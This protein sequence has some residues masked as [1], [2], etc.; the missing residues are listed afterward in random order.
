MK[1][2]V[3]D[4]TFDA[5]NKTI[6][7][8]EYS[9]IALED[10]L[11]ITNVEDNIIIYLFSDPLLGGSVNANILTLTYNSAGMNNT[12]SLQIWLELSDNHSTEITQSELRDLT[13]S[14]N[15][16]IYFLYANSPR[17]DSFN[18]LTINGSE[19]TQPVS[20]TVT[21]SV[22]NATVSTV[23][24]VAAVSNIVT[25]SGQPNQYVGQDVPM[26]V[27]DNIKIT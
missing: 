23:T 14:I 22:A 16:L 24:T 7:F 2:L 3:K 15:T 12:D 11:M 1:V 19:I 27:Y 25:L 4:Y 26:H 13:N 21:A 5:S 10:I 6:T 9:S 20:G 18:R 8:N 17:I